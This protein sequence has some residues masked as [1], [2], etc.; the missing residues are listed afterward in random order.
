MIL[1]IELPV[2]IAQ[3]NGRKIS[4][5]FAIAMKGDEYVTMCMQVDRLHTKL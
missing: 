1:V 2:T 5:S 3:R 4:P